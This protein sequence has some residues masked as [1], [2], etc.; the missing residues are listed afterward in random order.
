M[1]SIEAKQFIKR[2]LAKTTRGFFNNSDKNISVI[3]NYHSVHPTHR[4]STRPDDFRNQMEYL[5]SH[6]IIISLSDFYEMRV[7]DK[8]VPGR[9]AVVTFD[10]GYE[11]ND[12]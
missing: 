8:K 3:L 4:F 9:L 1:F 5:K 2:F 11:D 6:F 10:D 12:E 7:A